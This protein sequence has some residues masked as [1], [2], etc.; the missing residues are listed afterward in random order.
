MKTV[1]KKVNILQ[2][3]VTEQKITCIKQDKKLR[4]FKYVLTFVRLKT[5]ISFANLQPLNKFNRYVTSLCCSI[6]F[7]SRQSSNSISK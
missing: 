4:V 5:P 6:R 2:Q 7:Y 3:I 1:H